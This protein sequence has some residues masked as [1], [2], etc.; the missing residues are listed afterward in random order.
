MIRRPP[1]STRTDTLFP[2]TTL[3]RSCA[4]A[5]PDRRGGGALQYPAEIELYRRDLRGSA[6]DD[7]D[8]ARHVA[9]LQRDR[10]MA[11]RPAGRAAVG[12]LHPFHRRLAARGLL[13]RSHRHGAARGA[14]ERTARDGD[15]LVP[16][17]A[18]PGGCGM[19]GLVL[20]RRRLIARARSEEHTSELQ[21]LMRI[22]YADL[23]LQKKNHNTTTTLPNQP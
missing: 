16:P 9:G 6:A 8:R 15:R 18:R 1:R 7:R 23:C 21:S 10:A 13:P 12:A 17:A 3:F 20:P 22:S 4:A 11:R 19:S 14:G 2:Y 5:L